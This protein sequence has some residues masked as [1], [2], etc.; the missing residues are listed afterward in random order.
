[1]I[2]RFYTCTTWNFS[3]DIIVHYTHTTCTK[4]VHYTCTTCNF[5]RQYYSTLQLRN[6]ILTTFVKLDFKV[7]H[8]HNLIF[9]QGYDCIL[10]SRNLTFTTF[11][12]LDFR[13][14]HLHNLKFLSTISLYTTF[15]Q[16]EIF[17]FMVKWHISHC[18]SA[19]WFSL[20]SQ[21]M[22]SMAFSFLLCM[23]VFFQIEVRILSAEHTFNLVTNISVKCKRSIYL[24]GCLFFGVA[25]YRFC[26]CSLLIVISLLVNDRLCRC[27][28]FLY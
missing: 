9:L 12:Q 16:L 25:Y 10:H 2:S 13:V 3:E 18:T 20:H 1:M 17:N 26:G 19:P 14:L 5:Y 24:K 21:N 15:A 22:I 6:L 7:L 28:C 11:V 27:S 4:F 23:Q 8:Q